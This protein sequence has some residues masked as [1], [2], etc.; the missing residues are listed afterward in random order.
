MDDLKRIAMGDNCSG[1]VAAAIVGDENKLRKHLARH[2]EDVN[3]KI[4]GKAAIHCA[5]LRGHY[6]V[7]EA[8]LEYSANIEIEVQ[9]Y[10]TG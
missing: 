3:T 6:N 7:L 5:A 2:P 1:I 8:L 9:Y 10:I 4:A